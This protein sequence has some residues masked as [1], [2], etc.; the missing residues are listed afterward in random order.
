MEPVINKSKKRNEDI[1]QK[2]NEII[3]EIITRAK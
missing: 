3:D 2:H 1:I